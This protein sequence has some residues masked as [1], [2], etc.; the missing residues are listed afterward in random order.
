MKRENQSVQRSIG[1]RDMYTPL[2]IPKF[3]FTFF[4]ACLLIVL[5]GYVVSCSLVLLPGF[6][7]F[8]TFPLPSPYLAPASRF[9][10]PLDLGWTWVFRT[11]LVLGIEVACGRVEGRG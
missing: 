2:D 9:L 11:A 1:W 7:T 3:N 10:S 8:H 6:Y 4:F 5:V